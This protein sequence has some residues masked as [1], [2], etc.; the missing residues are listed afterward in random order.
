MFCSFRCNASLDVHSARPKVM[1]SMVSFVINT[2]LSF[3]FTPN[4]IPRNRGVSQ[5]RC[6]PAVQQ[7]SGCTGHGGLVE[8]GPDL[9]LKMVVSCSGRTQVGGGIIK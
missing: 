1:R 4:R 2:W 6:R 8:K 9:M 7:R 3:S 5:V